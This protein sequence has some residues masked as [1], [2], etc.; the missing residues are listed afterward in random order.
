MWAAAANYL[1]DPLSMRST[2][3]GGGSPSHPKGK[4]TIHVLHIVMSEPVEQKEMQKLEEKREKGKEDTKKRTKGTGQP[5]IRNVIIPTN[6]DP[7]VLLQVMLA[8]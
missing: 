6:W 2:W 7:F 5:T 4:R 3:V 1:N 8:Y